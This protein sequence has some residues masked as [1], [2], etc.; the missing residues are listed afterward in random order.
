METGL[1]NLIPRIARETGRTE[2]HTGTASV[3]LSFLP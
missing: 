3:R 2:K 1:K